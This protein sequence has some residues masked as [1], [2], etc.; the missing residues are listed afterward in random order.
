MKEQDE[1]KE[2]F[3]KVALG[4]ENSAYDAIAQLDPEY[5]EKLKGLYVDGTFGREGA[6]PRK[7]KELVMI[8]ITCA[9]NRPRGVR[10]HCERALTLG[11]TPREMLEVMEVAAIPGGMPGLWLGVE[12]LQDVLKSRRQEF[13]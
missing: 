10:I 6:L 11:A 1:A 5:F 9:L 2:A 12:T 3:K 7:I 13:K 4:A 8:G